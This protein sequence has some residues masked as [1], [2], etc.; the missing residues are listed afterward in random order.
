M[1]VALLIIC[2]TIVVLVGW[3]GVSLKTPYFEISA[4]SK[5]DVISPRASKT[6]EG[7]VTLASK[8]TAQ[9][10]P[11]AVLRSAQKPAGESGYITREPI[12]R[13]TPT[14]PSVLLVPVGSTLSEGLGS[15]KGQ[16]LIRSR[17]QGGE[18][19]HFH[20]KA[21]GV[22]W[23]VRELFI[24]ELAVSA[25]L[26]KQIFAQGREGLPTWTGDELQPV[27]AF[28]F[29]AEYQS[30]RDTLDT[31]MQ[32]LS[33]QLNDESGA[34]LDVEQ[35]QRCPED[36]DCH[37]EWTT[38]YGQWIYRA[39]GMRDVTLSVGKSDY[40]QYEFVRGG[41]DRTVLHRQ[42]CEVRIVFSG[43]GAPTVVPLLMRP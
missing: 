38:Q 11:P 22:Q 15:L 5:Q 16:K 33:G 31:S 34:R 41:F 37:P 12:G 32:L 40:T 6:Q 39:P 19:F 2:A 7:H 30:L 42:R 24:N 8:E 36:K 35:F 20:Q 27:S 28:C 4:P 25:T 3:C 17:V 1:V 10:G 13:T 18:L 9:A 21:F 23:S 29:G 14:T 43:E 26:T